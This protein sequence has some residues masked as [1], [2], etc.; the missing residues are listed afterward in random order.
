M[1]NIWRDICFQVLGLPG[2][3]VSL[4][5]YDCMTQRKKN[6]KASCEGWHTAEIKK[7]MLVNV[8]Q[9]CSL[10]RVMR[11]CQQAGRKHQAAM[12]TTQMKYILVKENR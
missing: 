10:N 6:V 11:N 1:L 8:S 12:D 3:Y 7:R 5:S 2:Y 9:L 4:H